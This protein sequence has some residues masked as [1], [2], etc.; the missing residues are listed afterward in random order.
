MTGSR[1]SVEPGKS[2][3]ASSDS[4]RAALLYP[5]IVSP[6]ETLIT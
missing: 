4:G 6:P 1:G 5:C 2:D 3:A